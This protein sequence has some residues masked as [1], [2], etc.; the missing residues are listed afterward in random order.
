MTMVWS[1]P[2]SDRFFFFLLCNAVTLDNLEHLSKADAVASS[3][4][5]CS[6][7]KPVPLFNTHGE[8]IVK[9]ILKILVV[10]AELA[11]EINAF[12]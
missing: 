2:V 4:P 8:F 5:V 3:L 10:C 9:H 6:D 1:S 7:F 11:I 12:L